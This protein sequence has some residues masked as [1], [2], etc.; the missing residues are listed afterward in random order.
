MRSYDQ[1]FQRSRSESDAVRASPDSKVSRLLFVTGSIA[2]LA[3]GA[4]SWVA[5]PFPDPF[6]PVL[7]YQYTA[8][9]DPR[10]WIFL[11][12]AS[13]CIARDAEFTVIAPTIAQEHELYVL[14]IGVVA[15]A[16]PLP[17][18]YFGFRQ[19]DLIRRARFV[20]AFDDAIPPNGA[21]A[22]CNTAFGVV[23][24]NHSQ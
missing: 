16:K 24:E 15:H 11:Q 22:T 10:F 18:A 23:Y 13:R 21:R 2:I 12:Q 9:T 17:A 7:P 14:G 6:D 19:P 1:L 3:I 20:A 8:S 4:Q 5:L